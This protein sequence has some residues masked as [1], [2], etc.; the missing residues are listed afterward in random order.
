MNKE[1]HLKIKP[2]ITLDRVGIKCISH[3]LTDYCVVVDTPGQVLYR[4]VRTHH[5]M[6]YSMAVVGVKLKFFN[7][8]GSCNL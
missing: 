8:I 3:I 4:S 6:D 5:C 7:K 1:N 2:T